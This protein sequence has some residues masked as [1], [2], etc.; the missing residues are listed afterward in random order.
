M[1]MAYNNWIEKFAFI[2]LFDPCTESTHFLIPIDSSTNFPGCNP[3][4]AIKS[5]PPKTIQLV[6]RFTARRNTTGPLVEV[7]DISN[8]ESSIMMPI[9]KWKF[10][11]SVLNI[12]FSEN[13]FKDVLQV[14]GYYCIETRRIVT[15]WIFALGLCWVFFLEKLVE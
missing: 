10:S 15:A 3:V 8:E 9:Y 12:Q 14:E 1:H 7:F 5:Y 11:L 13:R 2:Y 4:L 6:T